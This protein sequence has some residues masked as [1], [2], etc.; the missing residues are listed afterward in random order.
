MTTTSINAE[1]VLEVLGALQ[2]AAVRCWL[3]GSWGL[4]ALVGEQTRSHRDVDILIARQDLGAARLA[5]ESRG[6]LVALDDAPVRLV[7][8]DGA[9]REVDMPTG[10]PRAGGGLDVE[11]PDGTTM[12]LSRGALTRGRILGVDVPALSAEVHART[13]FRYPPHDTDL[14][15]M[16]ILRGRLGVEP[17]T[18]E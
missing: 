10:E 9:G 15:D 18:P 5:L 2:T 14:H 11:M 13:D 12:G 6:F 1:D 7:M 17:S 8:N 3:D 4:D 16:E